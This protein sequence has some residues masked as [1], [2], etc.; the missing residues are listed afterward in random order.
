MH[1]KRHSA[2]SGL[3][4]WCSS[5]SECKNLHRYV[6]LLINNYTCYEVSVVFFFL[7]LVYIL[8]RDASCRQLQFLNLYIK[9]PII[10]VPLSRTNLFS[11]LWLRLPR[12]YYNER[13]KIS[14]L[15]HSN[16]FNKIFDCLHPMTAFIF[17]ACRRLI[18]S[19]SNFHTT[20][21]FESYIF[22]VHNGN[23]QNIYT[24]FRW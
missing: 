2:I 11:F 21:C 12:Y 19:H 8:F 15:I 5:W 17:S 22:C 4:F 7:I 6:I 18:Q 16:L 9:K 10:M 14:I 13:S 3:F 1:F 24:A 20:I 23:F